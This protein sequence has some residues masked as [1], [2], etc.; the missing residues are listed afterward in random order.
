MDIDE[1]EVGMR[2]IP[3]VEPL[4][5]HVNSTCR[6]RLFLYVRDIVIPNTTVW[7]YYPRNILDIVE[8]GGAVIGCCPYKITHSRIQFYFPESLVNYMD[9]NERNF[10]GIGV[11]GG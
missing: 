5:E 10:Y 1:I 2:V 11:L 4:D 6:F 8:A 7:R 3:I 9:R